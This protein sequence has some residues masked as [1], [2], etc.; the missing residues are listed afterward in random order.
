MEQQEKVQV[1]VL[2]HHEQPKHHKW[3]RS[4][5]EGDVESEDVETKGMGEEELD[6]WPE[7]V[8]EVEG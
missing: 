3:K 5:E 2:H 4:S 8:A 1:K 6:K 7:G